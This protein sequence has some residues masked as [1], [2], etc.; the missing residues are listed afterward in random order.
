M[1]ITID[2]HK[3]KQHD[4]EDVSRLRC[5]CGPHAS[6]DLTRAFRLESPPSASLREQLWDACR[7][8]G[9]FHATINVS[10]LDRNSSNNKKNVQERL[11][12][13]AGSVPSIHDDIHDMM[14]L[15]MC[16]QHTTTNNN[17]N[18][19]HDDHDDDG[20]TYRG[21]TAESGAAGKN[22]SAE[23]KQSW[24]MRRCACQCQTIPNSRERGSSTGV[25]VQE[26]E[27]WPLA[28][29][30]LVDWTRDLHQVATAIMELLFLETTIPPPQQQPQP[31][32]P[33][34]KDDNDSVSSQ[35]NIW[36]EPQPCAATASKK[37]HS[38]SLLKKHASMT[39]KPRT[40]TCCN[41]DLLRAF[42]YDA[43]ELDAEKDDNNPTK[44]DDSQQQQMLGSSPHT[45]WG[46]LTVVWQDSKG[47]LQT[48]CHAHDQWTNV[49]VT[50]NTNNTT[51]TTNEESQTKNTSG[52]TTTSHHRN[53][54][55]DIIISLFVHVGDF[56]SLATRGAWP[57]PRHR[58]LCPRTTTTT[59]T[60][61]YSCPIP[62]YIRVGGHTGSA[63]FI[64]LAIFIHNMR[65]SI[66]EIIMGFF[67][68]STFVLIDG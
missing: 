14:S 15:H 58:V 28:R 23:P 33:S 50:T 55:E 68:P 64:S 6:V 27:S 12:S 7:R 11:L 63:S 48:Y 4:N 24:E 30:K 43:I 41:V 20:A 54:E 22:H 36:L 10:Q 60:S 59:T 42:C 13:L 18:N 65:G 37:I 57:S 3:Q 32:P 67:L 5:T 8:Q 38:L 25:N 26:D 16:S 40:I 53:E 17:N 39:N 66:E 29:Q 56:T 31:Q 51:I 9:C 34:P 49:E 45:D 47:G 35:H 2:D 61:F 52:I 44:D 62:I 19:N 46:T 1:A 21:R